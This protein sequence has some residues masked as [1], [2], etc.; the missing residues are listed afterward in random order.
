MNGIG[1]SFTVIAGALILCLPLRL[2]ILPLLLAAAYMTRGQAL[3]LGGASLTVLRVLVPIGLIRVMLRGESLANGWNAIDGMMIL[4]AVVL[5][6]TSPW[7]Q[8][9]AWQ[10]RSGLVWSDLGCYF[11]LRVFLAEPADVERAFKLVCLVMAPVAVFMLFEKATGTNLFGVLGGVHET[12]LV[13]EGNVRASGPFVHPILA[14]T[15]G[16]TIFGMA[17][18]LW[19]RDRNVSLLGLFAGGGI[20]AACASSG[21][22]LMV[23]F[24]LLGM[25]MWPL[26][27]QMRLVR[28]ASFASILALAAVMKDPVYFLMARIDI[29]GGSQGYY[30]AQLIRSSIEHLDEWWLAGTDYTRHWMQTG[31]H[32]NDRHADITNHFLAMGVM[33]GLP[34]MLVFAAIIVVAFRGVGRALDGLRG[35]A[36]HRQAFLAWTLGALL[37]GHL[38]N[39]MSISLFD[40]SILFLHIVLAA[41][42]AMQVRAQAPERAAMH[43]GQ[44]AMRPRPAAAGPMRGHINSWGEHGDRLRRHR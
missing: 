11:L 44:Q 4:W 35:D 3:D 10:F 28:W 41:I 9:G 32:A 14:G 13:R 43:R 39:F 8:F 42:G 12:A 31:I 37:F 20:V 33:G 27:E 40:Q 30:R 24:I 22:V 1:L 23:L 16:A 38:M 26:R 36:N 19:R 29:S 6:G 15:A 17:A 18:C 34:L 5:L 7:H 25:L 21:P 2:A